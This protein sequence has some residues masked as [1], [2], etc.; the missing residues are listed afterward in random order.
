MADAKRKMTL[1]EY[2]SGFDQVNRELQR[3][4]DAYGHFRA[5]VNTLDA[6][7]EEAEHAAALPFVIFR[8]PVS[9]AQVPGEIKL[10]LNVLPLETRVAFR[11][12]F[13]Q[14][15]EHCGDALL[16]AW[17]NI[18]TLTTEAASVVNKAKTARAD[19]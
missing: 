7:G 15:V 9:G 10:D 4:T 2:A 8:F 19:G 5:V 13:E 16:A 17:D 3:Q 1:E 6:D 11:P 12:L 18:I 14:L